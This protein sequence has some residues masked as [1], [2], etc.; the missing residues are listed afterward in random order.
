MIGSNISFDLSTERFFRFSRDVLDV[1]E[2]D[3]KSEVDREFK[4]FFHGSN[5]NLFAHSSAEWLKGI[6]HSSAF[7]FTLKRNNKK[8]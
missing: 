6:K 3:K 2:R 4:Q 8:N 7:P 5:I 1:Y